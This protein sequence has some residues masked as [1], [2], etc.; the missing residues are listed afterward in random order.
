VRRLRAEAGLTLRALAAQ[1][2]FSP[3]FVSQL[4]HGQVSPSI[5]S[6][7][8]ITEALGTSLGQFFAAAD[9]GVSGS[10]VRAGERKTLSSG[11]SRAQIEVM[12]D[13]R[14]A[15]RL[16][17]TIVTLL[18]GGRSGKHPHADP[19]EEFCLVLAGEVVLR[20]G[21]DE[22]VLREGD[23]V[24]VLPG[25]LRMWRN[26]R[27]QPARI[28]VVASLRGRVSPPL[29]SQRALAPPR[30]RSEAQARVARTG[31]RRR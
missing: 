17:A 14:P 3:S 26:E 16:E 7:E 6:M 27:R 21:P 11:W 24:T 18:A 15:G 8:K 10:I 29:A 12:S 9:G 5:N 22:H 1:T 19:R 2:G 25:E 28:A 4:E 30:R 31:I 23:A 13:A 20:L